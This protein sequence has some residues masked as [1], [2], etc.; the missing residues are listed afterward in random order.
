VSSAWADKEAEQEVHRFQDLVTEVRRFRAEQGLQ[1]KQ[2]VPAVLVVAGD[3]AMAGYAAALGALAAL[4][5]TVA[6]EPVPGWPALAAAGV[7]VA[8]DIAGSIDVPAERARLGKLLR[9]ATAEA[10]K[11][12]RKLGNAAFVDRAP[13]AEVARTRDRL[14]T[15]QADATRLQAQLDALPAA[16]SDNAQP[17]GSR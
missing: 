5:V 11:L 2:R 8:L 7:Q 16:P 9:T 15:A 14:A 4:D 17:D 10:D 13:A 1:P 6:A 3:P 12:G